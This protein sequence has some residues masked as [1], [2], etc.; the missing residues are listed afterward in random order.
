MLTDVI[1]TN[2]AVFKIALNALHEVLVRGTA[3]VDN[4]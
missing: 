4:D 2:I 3:A 1:P